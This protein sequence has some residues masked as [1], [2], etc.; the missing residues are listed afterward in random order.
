MRSAGR[1]GPKKREKGRVRTIFLYLGDRPGQHPPT[2]SFYTVATTFTLPPLG[3]SSNPVSVSVVG[4]C[5]TPDSVF[6]GDG[7]GY[8]RMGLYG[9]P[10]I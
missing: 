3:N 5:R 4:T 1:V 2:G 10:G 6:P 7:G 8:E 9:D